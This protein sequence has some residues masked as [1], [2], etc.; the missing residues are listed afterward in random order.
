[1]QCD[2]KKEICL[3]Y[4]ANVP[5]WKLALIL[6]ALAKLGDAS[7]CC[8]TVQKAVAGEQSYMRL[9]PDREYTGADQADYVHICQEA[10]RALGRAVYAVEI[11][12]SQSECFG[13]TKDLAYSAEAAYSSAYAE[14]E[15]MCRKHGCREVEYK[16]GQNDHL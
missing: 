7:R 5:E 12:L 8:G 2:E 3:N 15:S 11:V 14:L 9:H 10:A 4:A 1:M 16:H 13:L 6:D